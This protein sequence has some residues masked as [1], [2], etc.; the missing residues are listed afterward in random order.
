MAL[1]N[2][3]FQT[4]LTTLIDSPHPHRLVSTGVAI[5]PT[6]PRGRGE[7]HSWVTESRI[8]ESNVGHFKKATQHTVV[9]LLKEESEERGR[10][11]RLLQPYLSEGG[12]DNYKGAFSFLFASS[13]SGVADL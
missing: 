1:N 10:E 6:P 4:V 13:G 11:K 7:F 9:L 8:G 12:G 2:D 3:S 5:L